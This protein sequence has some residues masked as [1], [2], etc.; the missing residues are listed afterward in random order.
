MAIKEQNV[1]YAGAD[2]KQL[3]AAGALIFAADTGNVLVVYRS[4][5]VVDP[6]L[7]CG[8]GG[9]ME[10]GE[11]AMETS[12]REIEEEL[13]YKGKMTQVPIH[14]YEKPELKFHNFLGIV[15]KQ[16]N[17]ELNWETHGH[18]WCHPDHI[19]TERRHYGLSAV[20]EDKER[21]WTAY[22]KP[23]NTSVTS[24]KL[25]LSIKE[26][27]Y[28][29]S[30]RRLKIKSSLALEEYVERHMEGLGYTAVGEGRDKSVWTKDNKSVVVI[31]HASNPLALGLIQRW[32]QYVIANSRR[33]EHLP[34]L[35]PLA[36]AKG[37]KSLWSTFE[38]DGEKAIQYCMEKLYNLSS[39]ENRMYQN[40]VEK[41]DYDEDGDYEPPPKL[42]SFYKSVQGVSNNTN[43]KYLDLLGESG[44]LHNVMKRKDGTPVII[45][46]YAY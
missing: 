17:P 46:P 25:D 36:D 37:K 9:K 35:L 42:R 18:V 13:G 12:R 20:L 6:N 14:V 23:K 45:D 22:E 39:A 40:V 34:K 43:G 24:S 44:Q 31:T 38:H 33:D 27:G 10:T 1:Q 32:L 5:D 41:F 28:I 21:V 30:I 3:Q 15:P 7:W 8:A 16:F 4:S 11:D 29:M 26:I 19:P 2:D